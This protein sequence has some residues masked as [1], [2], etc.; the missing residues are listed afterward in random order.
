[1]RKIFLII[2]GNLE[3]LVIVAIVLF[4]FLSSCKKEEM[5]EKTLVTQVTMKVLNATEYS[6]QT[7]NMYEDGTPIH[8]GFCNNGTATNTFKLGCNY[9]FEGSVPFHG[10]DTI[11]TFYLNSNG[12][13]TINDNPNVTWANLK[14]WPACN[15]NGLKLWD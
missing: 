12:T 11:A 15:G 8:I 4:T 13:L 1:M 5:K 10:F 2:D 9:V 3:L 7:F 14:Y 6:F